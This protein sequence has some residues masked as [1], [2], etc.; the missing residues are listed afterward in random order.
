MADLAVVQGDG[1][2]QPRGRFPVER[3]RQDRTQD[4]RLRA[5]IG[6][7]DAQPFGGEL[8]PLG[9]GNPLDDAAQPEPAQI[10][11]HAARTVS[12]ARHPLL[13]GPGLWFFNDGEFKRSD[14]NAL[15][16]FG[17]NSKAGDAS[18][19][20]KF[21][22]GMKSVFH[23]CEALF[24]M[25]CDGTDFHHEGLTPWKQDGPWPHPEWDETDD[26]DWNLLTDLGKALAKE[27]RTRFLLWLPLRMRMHMYTLSGQESAPIIPDFP[28]DDTSSDALRF[29]RQ[30]T[31]A[32]DVAEIL[33]LL[34]HLE[35]VEHRGKSNRFVLRLDGARRLMGD[36]QFEGQVLFDDGRLPLDFSGRRLQSSDANGWFEDMRKREEW[37]CPRYLDDLGRECQREDKTLPEAAVL[38]CAGRGDLTRSRLQWAV[39]L[40]P[41]DGGEELSADHGNRGHSLVLHG[42]FFVDTGRKEIDA[43]EYL[44][45][46][47]EDLGDAPDEALL[48]KVWNQRLAQD[49]ML[50]LVLPALER[51]A[52]Q[53]EL[54]D[55]ECNALTRAL[56]DS[57]WFK[58]FRTH[59]C[60][61]AFWVRTLQPGTDPQWRLITGES[62]SRLRPVPTPPRSALD[63]PWNVFPKLAA[64]NVTPYDAGASSLGSAPSQWQEAELEVLLSRADGLF[65]GTPAMDYLAEF[66]ES[67]AGRLSAENLQGL[68]IGTLRNGL[69]TAE[70]RERRQ[71]AKKARRL[72]EFVKPER[73]LALSSELPDS[74]LKS[75]WEIDSPTL[76]VPRDL[77]PEPLGCAKPHGR[78]LATWLQLLDRALDLNDGKRAQHPILEVMQ[79]LL[80]TLPS[81]ARGRFLRTNPE[82]RVV[83]VRDA[84]SDVEKPVSFQYL[85]RV[86]A[87][88]TLFHFAGGLRDTRM[89]IAPLLAQAI[90]DA[91]V[92]LVRAQAYRA[93]FPDDETGGQFA[94][95]DVPTAS[96]GRACLAAA[97]RQSAGR[98]GGVT[99]RRELLERANDPGAAKNARRGLRLLL[100]G[101]LDRRTDDT[102]KLWISR[103]DQ[104]PAWNRLWAALH[105]GDQW[106]QVPDELAGTIPRNRWNDA[107]I[108]EIDARSLIDELHRTDRGIEAPQEFS[109]E[110]R[111]EI[112]SRIEYEDLWRHLPLHT[113]VGGAPVSAAYE[114]VYL[115]PRAG[116]CDDPLTRDAT[117]IAPSPNPLV[118][119]QQERWLR[120]L[121]DRAR[122]EIALGC[123][124]ASGSE[125]YDQLVIPVSMTSIAL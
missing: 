60:R 119:R 51:Y 23:L 112:L 27:T 39:F 74:I 20:G 22:L 86:R 24:Y 105:K 111:D 14:A 70:Q 90:P 35:R 66:L 63:R 48:R 79:G 34:Q 50:P 40:P 43:R 101:S 54:S 117:L 100:H 36:P 1:F 17:I 72:I 18:T 38:F 9:V 56:S 44:D 113:T 58:T 33:P 57:R 104:H 108:A 125:G 45:R 19:I 84:R 4:A 65:V 29:L 85:D 11:G 16:S 118:G 82:L 7:R 2:M 42:Q 64:C 77:E 62:R 122:I 110:E 106:S 91:D 52:E 53:Q 41:D 21:G 61:D 124:R 69:R 121:D 25:A 116:R 3:G 93:L 47:P 92:C 123:C 12:R 8:I 32:R 15:R 80:E 103:Q 107:N 97:G 37:P 94:D 109:V 83:G 59:V 99:A 67:C 30:P 76:L 87:A 78:T 81:E 95:Q 89:G 73:R 28:G 75:L 46:D 55:D 96:D 31:L 10:V 102:A 115:A 6:Q 71:V 26:A 5:V 98:L 49:V 13:K 120:R 88:G 114:R 68:L